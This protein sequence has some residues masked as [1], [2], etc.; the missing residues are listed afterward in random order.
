VGWLMSHEP[1]AESVAALTAVLYELEERSLRI[2]ASIDGVL[3]LP[4]V[5]SSGSGSDSSRST[6]RGSG[7]SVSPTAYSQVMATTVPKDVVSIRMQ[8]DF[9]DLKSVPASRP[10]QIDLSSMR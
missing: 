3:R 9:R 4:D 2:I 5:P 10:V 1:G 6:T 8:G 7:R